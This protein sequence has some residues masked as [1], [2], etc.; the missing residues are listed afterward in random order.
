MSVKAEVLERSE[1]QT[2]APT[3]EYVN[4]NKWTIRPC[5]LYKEEYNDCK[6]IKGRFHQYFI[7]GE[8]I[9]CL[10]WKRDYDNCSR[11]EEKKD[12]KAAQAVIHSEEDRRRTRLKAHFNND[13]WP[14]RKAPPPNWEREL[15]EWLQKR[16]EN[17]LLDVKSRQEKGEDIQLIGE[18]YLCTI[19]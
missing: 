6:S 4:E 16:N 10:Q 3:E 14:K 8:A 7:H 15:P 18:R 19:M 12:L 2:T 17:T 13:I 1:E 11:Y 9:D 5:F